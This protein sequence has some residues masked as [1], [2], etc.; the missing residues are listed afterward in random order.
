[1]FADKKSTPYLKFDFGEYNVPKN[2]YRDPEVK[3]IDN[4]L[5]E[6]VKLKYIID[7][8]EILFFS[9]SQ[10]RY[11]YVGLHFKRKDKTYIGHNIIIP[12]SPMV[13]QIKGNKLYT[14]IS[15]NKLQQAPPPEDI[16]SKDFVNDMDKYNYLVE[17]SKFAK[18]VDP[19]DNPV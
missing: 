8:K 6:Y 16:D 10:G 5:H 17:I 1:Q 7:T 15:C 11:L 13:N 18:T 2:I 14:T 9:I 12:S 3:V 19:N 4:N